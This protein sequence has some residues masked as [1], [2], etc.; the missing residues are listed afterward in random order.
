M[1]ENEMRTRHE[2][3]N[4]KSQILLALDMVWFL[5]AQNSADF[6]KCS[7]SLLFDHVH[8]LKTDQPLPSDEIIS[9]M[10]SKEQFLSHHTL[11]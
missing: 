9:W 5:L 11:V 3:A 6:T 2:L 1:T 7:V 10:D 8:V 4:V